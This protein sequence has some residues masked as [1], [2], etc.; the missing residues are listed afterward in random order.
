MT[1]RHE[2]AFTGVDPIEHIVALAKA[3]IDLLDIGDLKGW[4]SLF[5]EDGVYWMPSHGGQTDPH[6]EISLFF[7]DRTLMEIRAENYGHHLSASMAHPIRSCRMMDVTLIEPCSDLGAGWKLT[8]KFHAVISY[9]QQQS[10]FA[11]RY[12]YLV[13]IVDDRPR[14]R[15][16]RVDLINADSPLPSIMIYI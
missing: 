10:L 15:Q 9:R 12:E 13:R 1:I 6:A 14:I 16:K 7:E 5:S 3:E 8:A 4:M 2:R 11:G